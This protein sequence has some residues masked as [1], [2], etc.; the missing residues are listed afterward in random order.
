MAGYAKDRF[1]LSF[2]EIAVNNIDIRRF[3][4]EQRLYAGSV[5]V[6]TGNVSVYNDNNFEK[7]QV[8]RTGK[9]PHQQL[10]RVALEMKLDT[11][12]LRNLLISYTEFDRTSKRRG[13]LTFN[14]TSGTMY[15]L[16][17]DSL[18]L[19]GNNLMRANLSTYMLNSAKLNVNFVFNLTDELG[20]FSYE[21]NIGAF[22]GKV[23][24]DLT[25]PLGM[26]EVTNGDVKKLIFKVH[27]NQKAAKGDMQF[28]YN[29]LQV[30]LLK[31]DDRS[32]R[33]KNQSVMS[34]IANVFV[35][36]SDNPNA[37]GRFTNGKIAYERPATQ[38]FFAYIWRSLFTGIK[39]SVGVSKEKE[40]RV[41]SRMEKIKR[42]ID[43]MKS[44]KEERKERRDERRKKR[45]NRQK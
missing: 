37:Q 22:N 41:K 8:D 42:F 27:A 21:G 19:T 10:Q 7:K 17:N 30:Q 34:T 35:I 25:K 11:I 4:R 20:A 36:E 16:T 38:S 23:V 3:T 24:N 2:D 29:K 44:N 13:T 40:E 5:D 33:L 9:F 12:N 18:G 28:F 32:G 31:R 39:E 45:Q 43:R 1:N 15:N 6:N 14:R 26:L